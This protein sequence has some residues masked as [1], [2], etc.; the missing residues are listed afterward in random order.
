M[1]LQ[2]VCD[3]K[4]PILLGNSEWGSSLS[5]TKKRFG[6]LWSKL[7]ELWACCLV[8]D[9]GRTFLEE[10]SALLRNVRSLCL[11]YGSKQENIDS[12]ASA[13][14]KIHV[15]SFLQSVLWAYSSILCALQQGEQTT[16]QNTSVTHVCLCSTHSIQALLFIMFLVSRRDMRADIIFSVASLF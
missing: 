15:E 9:K 8:S 16:L 10:V 2:Y 1:C 14:C 12:T 5:L 3:R 4:G 13:W 11:F 7:C 6:S